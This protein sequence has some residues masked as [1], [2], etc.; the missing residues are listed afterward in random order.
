MNGFRRSAAD[1]EFGNVLHVAGAGD[2][3]FLSG[4]QAFQHLDLADGCGAEFNRRQDGNYNAGFP[5]YYSHL[6]GVR[7]KL[8]GRGEC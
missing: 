2:D 3:D 6:A 8:Q 7:D 5:A 4:R 1:V